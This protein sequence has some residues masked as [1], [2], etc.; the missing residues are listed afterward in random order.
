MSIEELCNE[1]KSEARN[2]DVP[3]L[4]VAGGKDL[5]AQVDAGT[6]RNQGRNGARGKLQTKNVNVD[7]H[8]CGKHGHMARDCRAPW[9]DYAHRPKRRETGA[10]SD[11]EP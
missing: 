7:C 5:S 2:L 10:G 1:I 6:S 9:T 4:K 3:R 11:T 8:N